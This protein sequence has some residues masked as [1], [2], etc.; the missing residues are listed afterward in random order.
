ML[1]PVGIS[2]SIVTLLSF[3]QIVFVESVATSD[4]LG[5]AHDER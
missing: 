5:C 4:L 2:V 1:Q 3:V